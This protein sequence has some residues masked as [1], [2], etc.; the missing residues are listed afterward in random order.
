MKALLIGYGSIGKRHE[1]VLKKLGFNC[2]D[3]VSKQLLNH[4]SVY[5]QLEAVP[6]LDSYDY[7]LIASVTSR[8]YE[9][10]LYLNEH[11]CDKDIFVEK[12]VFDN[13]YPPLL[14]KN[15]I[16]VGYNMRWERP[17]RFLKQ[18][19][20]SKKII[21]ALAYVGQYLPQ[22][23]PWADY[24]KSYS[25]SKGKGGGVALDLS[26]EIDYLQWLIG[27]IQNL[28]SIKAKISDLDIETEDIFTFIGRT[29]NGAVINCTMDYLNKI[30]QRILILHTE[31]E[32][33]FV[34]Y[35]SGTIEVNDKNRNKQIFDKGSK[36]S[37]ESY[38]E[39]HKAIIEGR[40]K[41]VCNLNQA[42][43]TLE[44]CFGG[45]GKCTAI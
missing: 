18:A 35:I 10:L 17:L 6:E 19:L 9:Q 23:H 20:S 3:I 2:I 16:W 41:D 26:H 22:W 43:A 5:E 14:V 39:M 33:W 45:T 32:T 25:A 44:I 42:L 8:H 24:R 21:F 12:A 4:A 28:C 36:D 37:D 29:E 31:D 38:F 1:R 30:T 40:T 15:R 13:R 27:P 11:I 34:D 7:Y